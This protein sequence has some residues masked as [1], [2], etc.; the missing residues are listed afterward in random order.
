MALYRFETI[1]A[2]QAMSYTGSS[3]SLAF[4]PGSLIELNLAY[5]PSPEQVAITFNGRT[6]NFGAGIYGDL[7]VKFA[8]GGTFFIGGGAAENVA[9]GAVDDVLFGGV[10]DDT[11][12]GGDGSD[13]LQGNQGADSLA[14]GAGADTVYGGQDNDVIALGAGSDAANF[15]NGNKGDDT[16]TALSGLSTLLGGQGND[17]LNGGPGAEILNGNLG[18]DILNGG[19]GRDLLLGE[20]GADIFV[21]LTAASA[22][23]EDGADR[24][25]GWSP[26]DRISLPVKGGYS[27]YGSVVGDFATAELAGHNTMMPDPN[28]HILAVQVNADVIVFADTDGD[29]MPDLAII[30][31]GADLNALDASNFV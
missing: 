1:T 26:L 6:V 29:L 18:D 17:M 22:M 20:G 14:G 25:I 11:L 24:I 16:I 3:D 4:D 9:G 2:A 21:F 12:S 8:G 10:G 19:G 30:L 23:T 28:Q 7:D 31:V 27:E 15:S 5:I 13:R